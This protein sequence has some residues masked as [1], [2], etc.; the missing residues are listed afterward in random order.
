MDGP[1][2]KWL[3][4]ALSLPLL[5]VTS[6]VVL[7]PLIT[8][9]GSEFASA[10]SRMAPL[11]IAIFGFLLLYILVVVPLSIFYRRRRSALQRLSPNGIVI[12]A[13]RKPGLWPG[14][15]E[16][17]PSLGGLPKGGGLGAQFGV[18]FD[19]YGVSFWRWESSPVK[20]VEF[21]WSQIV[22][23]ERYDAIST[24]QP[25]AAISLVVTTGHSTLHLPFS[26]IA[27]IRSFRTSTEADSNELVSRV[28][29][30]APQLANAAQSTSSSMIALR[31]IPLRP[32]P[33]AA[34]ISRFFIPSLLLSTIGYS[35]FFL[36]YFPP[37][38]DQNADT[39]ATIF[40]SAIPVIVTAILVWAVLVGFSRANKREISAGYTTL[41]RSNLDVVQVLPHTGVVIREAG[42]PFL[43]RGEIQAARE[44]TRMYA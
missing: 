28:R 39:E 35:I 34:Q 43:S 20:V 36:L 24:S 41:K 2:P 31:K 10:L 22:S 27:G 13:N 21:A 29:E 15:E 7:P 42:S 11:G 23:V 18:I 44:R 26:F 5:A 30:L 6:L 38:I 16:V 17:V 3:N 40:P 1:W 25:A 19:S 32:G 8:S 4:W 37:L 12:L 33:S 14:V 9:T